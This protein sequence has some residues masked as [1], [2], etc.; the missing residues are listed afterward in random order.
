M[1]LE[2]G[3]LARRLRGVDVDAVFKGAFTALGARQLVNL[4]TAADASPVQVCA[5]L[6]L[7]VRAPA[8]IRD[9]VVETVGVLSARLALRNPRDLGE[10]GYS[11]WA[12]LLDRAKSVAPSIYLKTSV[13]VLPIALKRV[14][15]PASP[16]VTASFP[17]IYKQLIDFEKAHDLRLPLM[18]VPFALFL[19]LD[20]PK[21]DRNE[22][23]DAFMDSRW[24]PSDLWIA[25]QKAGIA[26]K[27]L[28][29]VASA[30]G[31]SRYLDRMARD[32][33]RLRP[34]QAKALR[35][36]LSKLG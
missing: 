32:A 34:N 4:L 18:F 28:K 33:D 35:D 25:A 11:D 26:Q 6:N 7:A 9:R 14:R 1:M 21:T 29:R 15:D 13:E 8:S 27:V 22:L 24:P 3:L 10:G 30:R 17:V 12:A 20:R 31:G 36:A 5:F 16:L 19:D 23:V 2:H